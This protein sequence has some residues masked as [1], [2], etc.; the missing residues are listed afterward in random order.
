MQWIHTSLSSGHPG[1]AT[2]ARLISRRY[3][4]PNWREEVE[5]F[6]LSCPMCAQHKADRHPPAGLLQ[7][8]PTPQRPWSH[9]TLDFLTDLPCSQGHTVILTIVDCFSRMCR[10]LPPPKLPSATKLAELLFAWVFCYY[11]IPENIVSDRGPQFTSRVFRAFCK[12]LNVSL[13]LSSSYHP[14]TNGLTERTQQEITKILR[15][16][17]SDHPTQWAHYLPWAEYT[18]NSHPLADTELTSFQCVL[19]YQS[20][21]F[22]WDP[23]RSEIPALDDWFQRSRRVWRCTRRLLEAGAQWRKRQADKHRRPGP[24]L[25]P[26]QRLATKNLRLPGCRKLAPRYV[27]PYR[28]LQVQSPI[29][30]SSPASSAFPQSFIGPC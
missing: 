15:S 13:S 22:P 26:G 10:L 17:C 28:I 9:I 6:V 18:H 29:G 16:L 24:P 2:T 11:G 12:L 7:T 8:L 3:W 5:E 21:L 23:P 20:P 14:Q 4:W 27:G 25:R 19:W 30:S 1:I